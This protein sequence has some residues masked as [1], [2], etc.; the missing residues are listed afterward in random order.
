MEKIIVIIFALTA[1]ITGI[2]VSSRQAA[3]NYP[4]PKNDSANYI[5]LFG[6]EEPRVV[7]G[8]EFGYFQKGE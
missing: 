5:T 1:V 8:E 3:V 6:C 4:E 7:F 2:C